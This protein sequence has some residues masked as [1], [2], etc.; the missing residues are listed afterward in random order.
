M[1][2]RHIKLSQKEDPV[3][4]PEEEE[5]VRQEFKEENDNR[6]KKMAFLEFKVSKMREELAAVIYDTMNLVRKKQTR[7]YEEVEEVE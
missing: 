5:K 4:D 3:H 6:R 2:K 1:G 7:G